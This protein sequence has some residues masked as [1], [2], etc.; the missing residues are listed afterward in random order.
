MAPA[1]D[2][3]EIGLQLARRLASTKDVDLRGNFFDTA[4][5]LHDLESIWLGHGSGLNQTQFIDLLSNALDIERREL[6]VE[7]E[8]IDANFDGVLSWDELISYLVRSAWSNWVFIN[9]LSRDNLSQGHVTGAVRRGR[10]QF[11]MT[12]LHPIRDNRIATI[13]FVQS[14]CQLSRLTSIRVHST[15][16]TVRIYSS[17]SPKLREFLPMT[18]RSDAPL[19]QVRLSEARGRR[20]PSPETVLVEWHQ[21]HSARGSSTLQTAADSL[22]G[23]HDIEPTAIATFD[24]NGQICI[25][26]MDRTISFFSRVITGKER[27]RVLD[28]TY[29]NPVSLQY[30]CDLQYQVEKAPTFMQCCDLAE[31]PSVMLLADVSGHMSVIDLTTHCLL[32]RNHVQ[33][34]EPIT[35]FKLVPKVGLATAGFDGKLIISD[36][37]RWTPIISLYGHKQG[38]FGLDYCPRSRM[39]IT[40]G[41]DG[42]ILAWDPYMS[43]PVARIAG[44]H[45]SVIQICA[46]E[47]ENQFITVTSDK[48]IRLYDIRT[49]SCI[50]TLLESEM[51]TPEDKFTAAAFDFT[52]KQLITAGSHLRI[53]PVTTYEGQPKVAQASTDSNAFTARAHHC[54]IVTVRYSDLFGHVVSVGVDQTV[55]VWDVFSGR[56]INQFTAAPNADSTAVA[57]VDDEKMAVRAAC[58]DRRGK[59]L[60]TGLATGELHCWNPHNGA[61]LRTLPAACGAGTSCEVTYLHY[62]SECHAHPVVGLIPAMNALAWWSEAQTTET[63]KAMVCKLPG[64]STMKLLCLHANPSFVVSGTSNGEVILW[65]ASQPSRISRTYAVTSADIGISMVRALSRSETVIA[66]T[67][68]GNLFAIDTSTGAIRGLSRRR[69]PEFV[70]CAATDAEETCVIVCDCL[71]T[72]EIL[73][74]DDDAHQPPV[75]FEPNS[76]SNMTSVTNCSRIKNFLIASDGGDMSLWSYAG[77]LTARFGQSATW[78]PELKAL[79]PDA[80]ENET[81]GWD[82]RVPVVAVAPSKKPVHYADQNPVYIPSTILPRGL[83]TRDDELTSL[84]ARNGKQESGDDDAKYLSSARELK[85]AMVEYMKAEDERMRA[86]WAMKNRRGRL[87]RSPSIA[88]ISIDRGHRGQTSPRMNALAEMAYEAKSPRKQAKA[89]R[90]DRKVTTFDQPIRR[91]LKGVNSEA[92]TSVRRKPSTKAKPAMKHPALRVAPTSTEAS[93]AVHPSAVQIID[94]MRRE[95]ER[96]ASLIHDLNVA[97][98]RRST[99]ISAVH[100]NG[101][102]SF[103]SSRSSKRNTLIPGGFA[104]ARGPPLPAIAPASVTQP[105]PLQAPRKS[106]DDL[107]LPPIGGQLEDEG[108]VDSDLASIVDSV[109]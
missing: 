26:A 1:D 10:H 34:H 66:G 19:L 68:D 105:K 13:W 15:D 5:I 59:R 52:N 32:S 20:P 86:E 95:S 31:R 85:R 73:G 82:A 75:R 36:M 41:Y 49:W 30:K 91:R 71:K 63:S 65:S 74:L 83:R 99:S 78:P 27:L 81:D 87:E 96:A 51:H 57:N 33:N 8:K 102:P 103:A 9:N 4:F 22:N 101:R 94:V 58:S 107:Y 98:D 88:R 80:T 50:Q 46:N 2:F 54:L 48:R 109:Y 89:K 77:Q 28:K 104:S 42:R 16:N 70:L 90:A 108:D 76:R 21:T 69:L 106:H 14:S 3:V 45:S 18:R 92:T 62:T 24:K 44:Q 37:T 64:G 97:A 56:R 72:A 55:N 39:I 53:W 93:A 7:F 67:T 38:I 11:M 60:F 100:A 6:E 61:L 12:R 29:G 47:D 79:R 40:A 84:I 17:T 43:A 23:K 25:G 35:K